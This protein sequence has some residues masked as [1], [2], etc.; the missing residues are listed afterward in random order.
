MRKP[1]RT[2]IGELALLQR[3]VNRLFERLADQGRAEPA[4][5]G[6][7]MPSIDVYECKGKLTVVV[8]VPSLQPDSLRVAFKDRALVVS[9]NRSERRPPAPGATFLCMERPQGRFVRTI[10]LDLA[11]EV[12]DAEAR[13]E[14]G[15]LTIMVPRLKD[16]R[17]RDLVIPITYKTHKEEGS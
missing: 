8:E 17:G 4:A 11:L 13:L 9:G 1:A 2:P 12:R 7:W 15:L 16:R 14:G 3:E 10:P 6:D 5:A